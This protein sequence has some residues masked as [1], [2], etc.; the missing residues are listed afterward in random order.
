LFEPSSEEVG[1]DEGVVSFDE[2]ASLVMSKTVIKPLMN[3][4]GLVPSFDSHTKMI[5]FTVG[6]VG[7]YASDEEPDFVYV[8]LMLP[9][10]PFLFDEN[11]HYNLRRD[12][13]NWDMYL[14]QYIYTTKLIEEMV[15]S[16]LNSSVNKKYPIIIIQSD[17]GARNKLVQNS[18]TLADYPEEYKTWIVN[19]IYAPK[20]SYQDFSQDMDPIN[21]FPLIFNCYFDANIPLK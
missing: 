3:E 5:E 16:I 10:M 11:G 6:K 8:H 19:A 7:L 14:G 9:H 4:V 12:Y 17:H 21:T 15:E 1:A 18:K 20:C 13:H 2:F